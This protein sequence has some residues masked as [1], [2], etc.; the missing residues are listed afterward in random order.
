MAAAQKP[1]LT[2]EHFGNPAVDTSLWY[3]SVIEVQVGHLSDAQIVHLVKLFAQEDSIKVPTFPSSSSSKARQVPTAVIGGRQEFIHLSQ[4]GAM[5]LDASLA[6]IKGKEWEGVI[7]RVLAKYAEPAAA[8]ERYAL[9][10]PLEA[11]ARAK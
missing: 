9:R 11:E 1:L 10:V 4:E 6:G 8:V 3:H 5:M 7:S 2:R